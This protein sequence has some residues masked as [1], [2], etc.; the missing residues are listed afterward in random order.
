MNLIP[1][2]HNADDVIFLWLIF[3]R[4]SGFIFL[5]PIF[6]NANLPNAVKILLCI[7]M[8]LLIS[9]L[10]YPDYRGADPR[11][12]ID[13]LLVG[14][15]YLWL[16]M[17][18]LSIKEMAVGFLIGLGFTLI[19]EAILL[20]G[21]NISS[22]IGFSIAEMFD[23][24]TQT[25]QTLVSQFLTILA[26]LVILGLDMHHMFIRC[27]AESFATVPLGSYTLNDSMLPGLEAGTGRIWIYALQISAVPFVLLFLVTVVLGL[28][29]RVMPE[30]NIFA[31][32]FPVRIA[33]GFFT[34]VAAVTYFPL[35]LK[36]MAQEFLNFNQMILRHMACLAIVVPIFGV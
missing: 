13:G 17:G 3:A 32:G 16:S 26:T 23:P 19:F 5:V 35:I 30:M 22:S 27:L 10:L 25:Q 8:T 15:D 6:S 36:G 31:V 28:M 20:A 11:Y 34:L 7:F 18:L 29:S 1:F 24:A 2:I 12:K 4:I 33:I 9:M 21:Q 14:A